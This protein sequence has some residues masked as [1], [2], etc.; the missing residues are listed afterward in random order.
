[1]MDRM[2]EVVKV[3]CM[4]F[5]MLLVAGCASFGIVRNDPILD[6]L[7]HNPLA[8]KTKNQPVQVDESE[9]YSVASR[10][11]FSDENMLIL[12]FSGGGTRAAAFAYGVMQ[13][14]RDTQFVVDGQEQRMLDAVDVISSVSGGSFTSAYYGLYGDKIFENFEPE[15][16]RK[17]IEGAL[18]RGMFFNPLHWFSRTGRT[19][20]AVKYYEKH[21]FHNAT[22]ADLQQKDGPLILINASD[23]AIGLRFSFIQ[24]YFNLLG[25]DISSFPVAGAVTASSAVPLLFDPVV[26]KNY[27]GTSTNLPPWLVD[28][29]ERAIAENNPQLGVVALGADSYYGDEKHKY[30]HF[31]DG[32][33]TD[34]LGLRAIYDI[35]EMSGGAKKFYE[36]R[37][38]KPPKRLVVISVNAVTHHNRKMNESAKNPSFSKTLTA[39]DG[40]QLIRYDAAT[41]GLFENSMSRWAEELSTPDRPMQTD[42]IQVRFSDIEDVD[43][44]HLLD[45]V[46]T[47]FDLTDKQVDHLIA[48]GRELLRNN[49]KFQQL[50]KDVK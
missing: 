18:I 24:E 15:F 22:F 50:L 39:M 25:S 32:G 30:A 19:E 1:M 31:V 35:V 10:A 6:A 43:L 41:L 8:K 5:C 23:L 38:K 7:T 14:L 27:S 9:V 12:A 37:D 48:A 42:F 4:G 45:A 13:E 21:L 46:P 40:L 16:L 11:N 33:I 2:I 3:Y 26:M 34:N 17:N 49:P 20:V 28:L 29:K 47:S 44:L 36:N